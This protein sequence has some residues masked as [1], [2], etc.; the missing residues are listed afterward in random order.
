MMPMISKPWMKTAL[1]VTS[2]AITSGY[3]IPTY[4]NLVKYSGMHRRLHRA[5]VWADIDVFW[6]FAN[7]GGQDYARLNHKDPSTFL[8][9]LVN[10]PTFTSNVGFASN[11]TT[12]YEDTNWDPSSDGVNF[13][14]D[15]ASWF[16]EVVD[17][18]QS[19]GWAFGTDDT[20]DNTKRVYIQPRTATDRRA[21]ALNATA[22]LP[23]TVVTDGHGFHYLERVNSTIGTLYAGNI[24]VDNMS[25]T[26]AARSTRTVIVNARHVFDNSVASFYTGNIGSLG[27]G[28]SMDSTKRTEIYDAI[29][30]YFTSL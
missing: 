13:T 21:F 1:N 23:S 3:A 30:G 22:S 20:S 29:H 6:I 19:A 11:G 14:Q 16:C 28:K 12:S 24:V 4:I 27:F 18:L 10:S 2:Q 5:S 15:D 8:I 7:D 26:S 25:T 9:T 17:N